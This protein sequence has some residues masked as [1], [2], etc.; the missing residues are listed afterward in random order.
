MMN[1]TSLLFLIISW[2]LLLYCTTI[3]YVLPFIS[4]CVSCLSF[5]V[6]LHVALAEHEWL[7]ATCYCSYHRVPAI[8][9]I[10]EMLPSAPSHTLLL[11]P[12]CVLHVPLSHLVKYLGS[13]IASEY[14]F[15][16]HNTLQLSMSCNRDVCLFLCWSSHT[17]SHVF[18]WAV[19][20]HV[21]MVLHL[22]L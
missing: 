22:L 9:L 17:C 5:C 3:S 12:H 21:G 11:L 14:E 13:H 18:Y 15:V 6:S 4:S 8:V 1:Q 20:S 19:R 7:H 10:S 16:S 2:H